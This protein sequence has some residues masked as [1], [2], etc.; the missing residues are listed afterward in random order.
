MLGFFNKLAGGLLWLVIITLV[1]ST[2]LFF[3][4]QMNLISIEQKN[5]SQV[6]NVIQPLAPIVIDFISG[7]LPFLE[8]LF[9]SFEKMFE[10]ITE[11]ER[12]TH[13]IIHQLKT[14]SLS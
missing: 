6:Y 1:F 9:D 10:Q 12:K 4:N 7:F 11:E 14:R 2:L 8:S 13:A 3:V 5:E